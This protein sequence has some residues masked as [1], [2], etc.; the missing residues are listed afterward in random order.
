MLCTARVNGGAWPH[1]HADAVTV[2]ELSYMTLAMAREVTTCTLLFRQSE[3]A[4]PGPE[5]ILTRLARACI[6][7]G[8]TALVPAIARRYRHADARAHMK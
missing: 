5:L 3:A 8:C 1:I 2:G 6:A 7:V 4:L